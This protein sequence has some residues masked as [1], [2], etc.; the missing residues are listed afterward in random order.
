MARSSVVD[1]DHGYRAF[2]ANM[3]KLEGKPSV[4]IGFL[5]DKEART[6]GMVTNLDI[7]IFN[8]FG[9]RTAPERSFMRSAFDENREKYGKLAE[10]LS[11][12]VVAGKMTESRAL[13]LLAEICR[14]DVRKKLLSNVPPPNAESTIAAKGHERTLVGGRVATATHPAEQGGQMSDALQWDYDK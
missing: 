5:E 11:L 8:E 3:K 14:S 4:R 2:M 1:I 12:A 9:T 6:D 7:A 13:G 10:K